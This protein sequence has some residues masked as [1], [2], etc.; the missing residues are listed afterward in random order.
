[1][2]GYL[3]LNQGRVATRSGDWQ[4]FFAD[5]LVKRHLRGGSALDVAQS[6]SL[7]QQ[8]PVDS[9]VVGYFLFEVDDIAVVHAMMRINPV[10]LAGGSVEIHR[11]VE[12]G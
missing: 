3:V 8:G 10:V 7:H 12:D 4:A 6:W 9:D 5:P 2:L 1:M 11:L